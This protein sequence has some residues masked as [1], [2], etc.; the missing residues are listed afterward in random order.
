MHICLSSFVSWLLSSLIVFLFASGAAIVYEQGLH[1]NYELRPFPFMFYYLHFMKFTDCYYL[2]ITI[3]EMKIQL[4]W[5]PA[6]HARRT[7]LSMLYLVRGSREYL[8]EPRMLYIHISCTNV[9]CSQPIKRE[10]AWDRWSKTIQ[11]SIRH[12]DRHLH[13][14]TY[15][16]YDTYIWC[17]YL[18]YV[19]INEVDI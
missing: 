3:N 19:D 4:E 8:Q 11:I 1:C 15:Y 18:M 5:N 13:F 7:S 10:S 14:R 2:W 16:A 12:F 9:Q 17:R 6:T